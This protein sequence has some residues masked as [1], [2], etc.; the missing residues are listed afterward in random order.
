[1]APEIIEMAGGVGTAVDIW[2]LGCTV[3]EFLSSKPPYFDLDPMPALFRIVQDD[4]PPFPPGVSP[5]CEDFLMLCFQKDPHLRSSAEDLLTHPWIKKAKPGEIQIPV[6]A[7]EGAKEAASFINDV[8]TMRIGMD[9]LEQMVHPNQGVQAEPSKSD[10]EPDFPSSDD[11]HDP[12]QTTKEDLDVV[13]SF[14]HVNL[15]DF[16]ESIDDDQSPGTSDVQFDLS[17][18]TT[19][20]QG[21]WEDEDEDIFDDFDELDMVVDTKAKVADE[22]ELILEGL[23]PLSDDSEPTLRGIRDLKN[24]LQ[25]YPQY[26]NQ[27]FN[28]L[29]V[30]SLLEMLSTTDEDVLLEI[31][32]LIFSIM[33]QNPRF[34]QSMSLAGLVPAIIKLIRD[35]YSYEVRLEASKFIRAFCTTIPMDSM[36]ITPDEI[37]VR[38][39]VKRIFIASGG[40]Q[41][42]VVLVDQRN[43]ETYK[44]LVFTGIDCIQLVLDTA[45]ASNSVGYT[46]PRSDFVRLFCKSGLITPLIT[47]LMNLDHDIKSLKA[48]Q[49]VNAIANLLLVFASNGKTLVKLYLSKRYI[50]EAMVYMLESNSHQVKVTI[51]KAIQVMTVDLGVKNTLEEVGFLPKLVQM[52]GS[53]H[54]DIVVLSLPISLAMFQLSS[55]RQEKLA[56]CGIIPLLQKLILSHH[57]ARQIPMQMICALAS[58]SQ[59]YLLHPLLI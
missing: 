18:L 26:V 20:A 54:P 1:M 30:I 17:K 58:T 6:D 48:A 33:E 10:S 46:N 32:S 39:F 44:D 35:R 57:H 55:S 41:A 37:E 49:Y 22:V 42:L 25:E 51:L 7:S 40:L 29:G 50:L 23:N 12:V 5:A 34:L 15:A 31:L 9:E 24:R 45:A 47:A 3:V 16:V 11:D 53:E 14:P 27:T 8:V 13:T 19:K 43:Y 28:S 36:G 2:S 4:H 38:H 52:M 59:K 56:L 21:A